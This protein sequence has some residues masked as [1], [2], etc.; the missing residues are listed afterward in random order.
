MTLDSHYQKEISFGMPSLIECPLLEENMTLCRE[1]GLDF[2]E[3]NMNLPQ[4]QLEELGKRALPDDMNFSLHLPEELNVWDINPR[5]K[6]AYL[7][8]VAEAVEYALENSMTIL[9]MHLNRGV[10]FTL[11]R[12]KVFIFE[13]HMGDYLEDTVRFCE[14]VS[15]LAKGSDLRLYIENTGIYEAGFIRRALE[16]I[17]SYDCFG[18][19]WDVGHDYACGWKDSDYLMPVKERIGHMHLH[20][21]LPEGN[22]LPLG[23][24]EI[25][26]SRVMKSVPALSTCVIETKTKEGLVR[27]VEYIR[28]QGLF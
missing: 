18:L 20:D 11:P 3:L 26:I 12:R 15:G 23:T 17:L 4:A 6:S 22:H 24:G 5:V 7:D 13:E 28:N 14:L 27:S 2:V 25:D 21:G 9:N 19:T 8:T 10:Y 1:L 16:I